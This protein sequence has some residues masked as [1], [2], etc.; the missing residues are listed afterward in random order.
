[1]KKYYAHYYQHFANTFDLISV[2]SKA[3]EKSLLEYFSRNDSLE[4]HVERV[5]LKDARNMI[6]NERLRRRFNPDFSG[7]ASMEIIPWEEYL[8]EEREFA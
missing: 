4:A 6:K 7:Y 2:K 3:E 5:S 1:M 8:R